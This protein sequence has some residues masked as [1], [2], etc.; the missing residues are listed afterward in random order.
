VGDLLEC[1]D[2]DWGDCA[3]LGHLATRRPPERGKIYTFA[4][5]D[6]KPLYAADYIHLEEYG[7]NYVFLAEH[8]RPVDDGTLDIFRSLVKD[9]EQPLVD[10]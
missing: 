6:K 8:F 5:V 9:P 3:G 1:I 4:G 2:D 10:A 7:P